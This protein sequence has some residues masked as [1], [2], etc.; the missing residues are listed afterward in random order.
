MLRVL[1]EVFQSFLNTSGAPDSITL[2]GSNDDSGNKNTDFTITAP[3]PGTVSF[4]G[5]GASDQTH[6][7]WREHQAEGKSPWRRH[8]RLAAASP[9]PL[10]APSHGAA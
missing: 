5:S 7:R 1:V 9:A 10:S 4:I 3:A 8:P 6:W 2:N